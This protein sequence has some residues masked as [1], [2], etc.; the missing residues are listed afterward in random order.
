MD[1]G[2]RFA[3]ESSSS[4]PT[5]PRGRRPSYSY[6][7]QNGRFAQE[8][9]S[10]F[11]AFAY[12]FVASHVG[13]TV[14]GKQAGI[15]AP[16]TRGG[17]V[18][19]TVPGVTLRET[20]MGV[21]GWVFSAILRPVCTAIAGPFWKVTC[22]RTL[23]ATANPAS[24]T[25]RVAVRRLICGA[26]CRGTCRRTSKATSTVTSTASCGSRLK[27]GPEAGIEPQSTQRQQRIRVPDSSLH[28]ALRSL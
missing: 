21:G 24:Q 27:S 13:E 10:H 22:C 16:R 12:L 23:A 20:P 17:T 1:A 19:G 18:P 5:A 8:S 25:N 11:G 14:C 2:A 15:D 9:S 3:Q 28:W 6:T 26:N 7:R 4:G